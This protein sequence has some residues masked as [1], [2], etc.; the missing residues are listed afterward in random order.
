MIFSHCQITLGPSEVSCAPEIIHS[1]QLVLR[2]SWLNNY[3]PHTYFSYIEIRVLS[4]LSSLYN[5]C[6]SMANPPRVGDGRA[7][8][9]GLKLPPV[10]ERQSGWNPGEEVS[11]KRE[12][13]V[14]GLNQ[15]GYRGHVMNKHPLDQFQ[16]CTLHSGRWGWALCGQPCPPPTLHGNQP[17]RQSSVCGPLI[18]TSFKSCR[19]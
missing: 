8:A 11:G 9:C 1:T 4:L 17:Q 7:R 6:L 10:M 3:N 5:F 14:M 18:N 15:E 2:I 12:A 16:G 19:T 13:L